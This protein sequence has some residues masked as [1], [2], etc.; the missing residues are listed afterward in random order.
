M[1]LGRA[2]LIS[3]DN[4]DWRILGDE[5]SIIGLAF[6]LNELLARAIRRD[7]LAIGI[8]ST[9]TLSFLGA[10]GYVLPI[11]WV[12]IPVSVIATLLSALVLSRSIK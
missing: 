11:V 12:A 3:E 2:T 7:R 1:A 10:V 9:L 4:L 5:A 6:G 8:L